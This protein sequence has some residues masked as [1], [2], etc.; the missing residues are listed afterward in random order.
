M[1]CNQSSETQVNNCWM[2]NKEVNE[3]C[4]VWV[5]QYDGNDI[6]SKPP[7]LLIVIHCKFIVV[8][9]Q[10]KNQQTLLALVQ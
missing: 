7:I 6:T 9:F 3:K 10:E 5:V 8:R 4:I 2:M 1:L